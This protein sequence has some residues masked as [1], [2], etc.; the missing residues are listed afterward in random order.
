MPR[1][2]KLE[3]NIN[4]HF[5]NE[6]LLVRALTHASAC[7]G[8][9]ATP[10]DNE[11][12]EFLGDRVLGLVISELVSERF[13]GDREGDLARRYNR[14]V[15]RNTCAAVG[16]DINIGEFIYLSPA[17]AENGGRQKETI[18]ANAVE[19]L[20]AAVFLDGGFEPARDVVRKLWQPYCD[21]SPSAVPAD[22]KSALQ[23]WAQGQGLALP[24]YVEISR[25]G[26]DHKPLFT[27]EVNVTG[28]P[29]A[30]GEG[31]SKRES[32]QAA[33]AALLSREG[34]WSANPNG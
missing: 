26:P 34:V 16:K 13:P 21:D 19:A 25:H 30:R 14:L 1:A 3:S 4:Y 10:I 20:L 22:A 6:E 12:L 24:Q 7:A 27:T 17:E 9:G 28:K 2:K 32:E 11:R 8:K 31:L 15:R 18:I 23:E 33:A 29:P 5:S